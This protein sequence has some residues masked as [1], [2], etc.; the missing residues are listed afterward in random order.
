M[1]H[2]E[3]RQL[4]VYD[5]VLARSDGRLGAGIK[6][7][8]MDCVA[9]AAADRAAADAAG[10]PLPR[11]PFPDMNASPPPCSGLRIG[12]GLEGDATWRA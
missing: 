12:K 4:S 9:K 1:T 5:L 6:P 7:S 8:E 2:V 11:P 10:T 3:K